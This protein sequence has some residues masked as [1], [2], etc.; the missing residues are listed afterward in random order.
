[1]WNHPGNAVAAVAAVA[2]IVD[3]GMARAHWDAWIVLSLSVRWSW[4]MGKGS[5]LTVA[6]L[7]QQQRHC[8]ASVE[9]CIASGH[10]NVVASAV[11][12][13]VAVVAAYVSYCFDRIVHSFV[14]QCP[15]HWCHAV[16][17]WQHCSQPQRHASSQ[18]V[19]RPVPAVPS[20]IVDQSL[21]GLN[22]RMNQW[23]WS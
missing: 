9:C 22:Q 20:T 16:F 21:S 5:H 13:A 17:H 23:L 19:V 6:P 2:G 15:F 10:L 18:A 1:M 4:M 3:V 12:I 7:V 14:H 11:D 8:S